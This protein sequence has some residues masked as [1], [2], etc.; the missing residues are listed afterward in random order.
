MK[1]FILYSGPSGTA[2][3][4]SLENLI[5]LLDHGRTILYTDRPMRVGEIDGVHYHF[6]TRDEISSLDPSRF[7]IGEVRSDLQAI[8]MEEVGRLLTRYDLVIA[9]VYPTLGEK[10][11]EW[12]MNGPGYDFDIKMIGIMPISYD[13]AQS[14]AKAMDVTPRELVEFMVTR[15]LE[16]RGKDKPEK[17]KERAAMA[18]DEMLMMNRYN[19]HIICPVGEDRKDEW[20][21]PLS[22]RAQ[23]VLDQLIRAIYPLEYRAVLWDHPEGEPKEGGSDSSNLSYDDLLKTEWVVDPDIALRQG[24]EKN[25]ETGH[26]MHVRI[27]TRGRK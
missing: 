19:E 12:I 5:K 24:M 13:D 2:K 21:E 16:R 3:G 17:I 11:L 15:K 20:E 14:F 25:A 23:A 26:R 6:R 8:D 7:I 9:E 22:P 27:E 10:L 4:P 1:Q 18:W